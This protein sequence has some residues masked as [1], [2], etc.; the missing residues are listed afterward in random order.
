[1]NFLVLSP[2]AVYP[3]NT[4]GRIGIFSKIKCLK[5]LHNHVEVICI[6]DSDVEAQIQESELLKMDIVCHS[7]NRNK[8]KYF[9]LIKALFIPY[10]VASRTYNSIKRLC[11]QVIKD[12]KID[13]ILVESPP[14]LK[15]IDSKIF[16]N[17]KIILCQHNIE[18]V[19]MRS[20]GRT[21]K[22]FFKRMIYL[23]ESVRLEAFEKLLYHK[24]NLSVVTFVSDE[25][26]KFFD[27]NLN[28]NKIPTL[29]LPVGAESH[30]AVDSESN[31]NNVVIVGK[32]SYAPNIEGILWFCNKVWNQVKKSV[33]DAQLYIVGKDP[34]KSLLNLASDDI[35]VTGTVDSVDKYYK[36]SSVAV[37]P[38]FSGGGVK[39]KLIEASSYKIPI[40]CTTSGVK[41]TMYKHDEHIL[42]SDDETQFADMVIDSLKNR[43]TAHERAERCYEYFMKNYQWNEIMTKFIDEI[44][45]L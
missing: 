32:M 5:Q 31:A 28:Y 2:E 3:P 25:D 8:K 1:M 18:Y 9:N 34:D 21:Q 37:I 24:K 15:N 22:N 45:N 11:G 29:L 33:P 23:F 14:M 41:G 40:V 27:D 7:I 43:E 44:T 38:L 16:D 30:E 39:T 13:Y 36:M 19:T 42:V 26:K 10:I 20:N 4:G 35:I 17:T 12:V 6:V